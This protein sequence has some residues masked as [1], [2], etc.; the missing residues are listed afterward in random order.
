MPVVVVQL[1]EGRSVEQKRQLARALSD[2]MVQFADA[3][4][5][6]LHVAIQEYSREQWARG[7]VLAVDL[8]EVTPPAERDPAVWH[9]DH[10]LLEVGDLERAEA[11]YLDLL[12]FSVRKRGKHRDGRSLVVTEQGLGLTTGG[13][14]RGTIE[15]LAFR[16]RN[17]A[18]LA[19]RLRGEGVEIVDGPVETDYGVSLY[20]RDPD[21]NKI[22][23]FGQR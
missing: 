6:A 13:G 19:E 17:V 1:W 18:L 10:M 2:A 5:D 20:V 23:F 11:F 21:G 9:L 4:P 14:G 15:H 16:T 3:S 7:G 12:G 22:E 8:D